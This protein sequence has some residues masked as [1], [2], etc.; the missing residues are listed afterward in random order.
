MKKNFYSTA[1]GERRGLFSSEYLS[2]SLSV[3]NFFTLRPG[4][5]SIS[6]KAPVEKN[7]WQPVLRSCLG[8]STSLLQLLSRAHRHGVRKGQVKRGRPMSLPE[9]GI[10]SGPGNVQQEQIPWSQSP[11]D[12]CQLPF[13]LTECMFQKAGGQPMLGQGVCV[14][15]CVAWEK[16]QAWCFVNVGLI[17]FDRRA[18]QERCRKT[19][20]KANA[21]ETWSLPSAMLEPLAPGKKSVPIL[22]MT[23]RPS[24]LSHLV[25]H[26]ILGQVKLLH[27]TNKEMMSLK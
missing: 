9:A 14:C 27:V 19:S 3:S 11:D 15:V 8:R 17:T 16:P 2:M 25:P 20:E 23:E 1:Q 12:S 4:N 5:V 10:P 18:S 6:W 7:H 24:H 21:M 26:N 22:T 13:K